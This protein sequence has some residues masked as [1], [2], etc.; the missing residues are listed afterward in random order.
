MKSAKCKWTSKVWRRSRSTLG[1]LAQHSEDGPVHRSSGLGTPSLPLRF[2]P[3]LTPCVVHWNEAN[4]DGDSL[5]W[6]TVSCGGR[7]LI[8]ELF[9][10]LG[11]SKLAVPRVRGVAAGGRAA[12]EELRAGCLLIDPS[13]RFPSAASQGSFHTGGPA[14]PQTWCLQDR[15]WHSFRKFPPFSPYRTSPGRGVEHPRPH[16]VPCKGWPRDVGTRH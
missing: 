1:K 14:N 6:G 16:R 3:R 13:K 5:V 10:E 12:G 9:S 4:G 15:K 11:C 7:E 8:E 2:A